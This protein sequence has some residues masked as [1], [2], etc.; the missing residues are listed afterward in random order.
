LNNIFL[1]NELVKYI[2]RKAL[3]LPVDNI[4]LKNIVGSTSYQ[5]MIQIINNISTKLVVQKENHLRCGLCNKGPFTKRGL[6]LHLN[7]VH[8]NNI[9]EEID[10]RIRETTS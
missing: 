9:L 4:E 1:K 8:F 5:L 2:I 3:D 6:Y 10:K 7:R